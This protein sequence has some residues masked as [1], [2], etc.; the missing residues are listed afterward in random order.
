[1][2]NVNASLL[3][4]LQDTYVRPIVLAE[5]D[6]SS[7]F[8]R[9]HSHVGDL[10]MD[11]PA[12]GIPLTFLG[13]GALGA[14]SGVETPEELRASS[15]SM[16]LS[17]VDVD[18]VAIAIAEDYQGRAYRIFLGALEEG[19]SG[20]AGQ[21]GLLL[22]SGYIDN[23]VID[24]G[25]TATISVQGRNA[26]SQWERPNLTLYSDEAQRRVNASDTF[27]SRITVAAEGTI[28]WQL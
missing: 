11:D 16:Q 19:A 21:A 28:E 5:L 10:V 7:G 23:M 25:E 9:V 2:R 13:I 26:L 22:S 3:S 4:A 8:V 1:M 27:C 15:I 24:I 12:T 6:F 20:L 14:I 18:N 17:G